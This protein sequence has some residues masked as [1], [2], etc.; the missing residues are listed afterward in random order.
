MLRSELGLSELR[1]RRFGVRIPAGAQ[2]NVEISTLI[3]KST[4]VTLNNLAEFI[5]CIQSVLN[6]YVSACNR[7]KIY[8]V[9]FC[10]FRS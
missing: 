4:V 9:R 7:I 10:L 6:N 8:D 2:L 1:I 3:E 5:W